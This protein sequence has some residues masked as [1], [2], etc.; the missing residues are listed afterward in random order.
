MHVILSLINKPQALS[1]Y[2]NPICIITTCKVRGDGLLS[3]DLKL[4]YPYTMKHAFL[5]LALVMMTIYTLL[6]TFCFIYR[7]VP[8]NTILLAR[9]VSTSFSRERIPSVSFGSP[10]MKRTERDLHILFL[11]ISRSSPTCP[12]APLRLPGFYVP[13]F[14]TR[15]PCGLC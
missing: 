1:P 2:N 3:E 5:I 15:Q 11:S 8:N 9:H 13:D 6:E 10:K 4:R 14:K 7:S 12:V